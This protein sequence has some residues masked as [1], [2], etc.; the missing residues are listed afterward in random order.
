MAFNTHIIKNVLVSKNF[1]NITS[2]DVVR[3]SV[4]RFGI[5][6]KQKKLSKH[7]GKYSVIIIYL[8]TLYFNQEFI[9]Y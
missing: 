4:A 9:A 8:L 6:R 2:A 3:K 1:S 5:D 7:F